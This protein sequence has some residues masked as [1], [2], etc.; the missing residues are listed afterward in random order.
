MLGD[1]TGQVGPR[2]TG[3]AEI[4]GPLVQSPEVTVLLGTYEILKFRLLLIS[5][6]K[7]EYNSN[8]DIRTNLD[9]IFVF[10]PLESYNVIANIPFMGDRAHE[11]RHMALHGAIAFLWDPAR[12]IPAQCCPHPVL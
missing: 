12:P 1:C 4:V 9:W 2:A 3:G 5:E 11:S 6:E 7:Y 10:I 8:E